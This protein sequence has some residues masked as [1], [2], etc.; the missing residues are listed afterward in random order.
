[1]AVA[2]KPQRK[3]VRVRRRATDA[4]PLPQLRPGDHLSVAEFQR[5]YACAP[6][7]W[8]AELI[9]G[10]VYMPSPVT[11]L[12]SAP[13]LDLSVWLGTYSHHTPSVVALTTQS[14]RLGGDNEVQPDVLLRRTSGGTSTRTD[15]GYIEGP[16]ELV[17]E[18]SYTSATYDLHVK[19]ALYER[20]GV[21][22]YLVWRVEDKAI[23][24]WSLHNG[25]YSPIPELET[26]IVE[27]RVF[28]G[29]RLDIHAML[30]GDGRTVLATLIA[31]TAARDAGQTTAPAR[32]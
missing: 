8:I 30:E 32:E 16:P 10:I 27:S 12:H 13:H 9:E 28:P 17:C 31:G 19:K 15:E 18:V 22:E 3:A 24:W 26:G 25:K 6:D 7:T 20:A 1:M 29:L 14:V 23:D 4:P 11:D 21:Q 2:T 5:R